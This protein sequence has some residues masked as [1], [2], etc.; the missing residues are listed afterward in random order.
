MDRARDKILDEITSFDTSE[1]TK[2]LINIIKSYSSEELYKLHKLNDSK[3][4]EIE[5]FLI[6]CYDARYILEN[7]EDEK[8]APLKEKLMNS[9][10]YLLG[11]DYLRN[12][13]VIANYFTYLSIDS[14]AHKHYLAVKE[15][16]DLAH[17]IEE[18]FKNLKLSE[19]EDEVVVSSINENKEKILL[20]QKEYE[21]LYDEYLVSLYAAS[22][23][24][25][26]DSYCEIF[27]V[28]M[29]MTVNKEIDNVFNNLD[30]FLA[31]AHI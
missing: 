12:M 4:K 26:L 23:N 10:F 31:I 2:K 16:R 28:L 15:V 18:L 3:M 7:I 17:S 20:S 21:K 5:L 24:N 14:L 27:W 1:E 8:F 9:N 19:N 25:N 29:Q 11:I 6:N 22:L 13:A 30:H